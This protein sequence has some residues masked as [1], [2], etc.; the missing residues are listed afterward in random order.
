[1]W[2][3]LTSNFMYG[4][5]KCSTNLHMNP[6]ASDCWLHLVYERIYIAGESV[7]GY[8]LVLSWE[9]RKNQT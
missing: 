6:K 7:L 9:R 5:F 8:S 3:A 2:Y 1:M 4:F